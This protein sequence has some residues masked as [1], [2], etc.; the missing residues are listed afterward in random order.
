MPRKTRI[1]W[2]PETHTNYRI[3]TEKIERVTINLLTL[4]NEA[5]EHN[6]EPYRDLLPSIRRRLQEAHNAAIKM[7]DYA[8][9]D[10]GRPPMWVTLTKNIISSTDKML[11]ALGR[12]EAD[13][14]RHLF[15]TAGATTE[16]MLDACLELI[17]GFKKVPLEDTES[18]ENDGDNDNAL[19]L[20]DFSLFIKK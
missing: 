7:I 1:P 10:Q 20:L 8:P 12:I 16:V 5:S 9:L 19:Y 15:T 17:E 3:V 2:P 13:T 6:Y 11:T 14:A 18:N 4:L